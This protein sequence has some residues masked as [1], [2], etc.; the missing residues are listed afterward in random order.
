MKYAFKFLA[1]KMDALYLYANVSRQR[2]IMRKIVVKMGALFF[3]FGIMIL[4]YYAAV[5]EEPRVLLMK[6]AFKLLARK[7]DA[8][9]LYVNASRQR[10]ITRIQWLKRVLHIQLLA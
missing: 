2:T 1:R 8:L 5:L 10:I 9:H 3:T 4:M 6:Y 7:M